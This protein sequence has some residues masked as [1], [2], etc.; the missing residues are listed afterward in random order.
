MEITLDA[1]RIAQGLVHEDI[2]AALPLPDYYGANL[3]ALYD[4]LGEQNGTVCTV[5]HTAEAEAPGC[6][7]AR[8]FYRV[9]R[10]LANAALEN[11]GFCVIFVK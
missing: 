1:R 11:P 4:I 5:E 10:V 6:D 2:C 7:P 9:K 3:D 8:H